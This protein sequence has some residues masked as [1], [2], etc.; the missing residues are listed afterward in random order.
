MQCDEMTNEKVRNAKGSCLRKKPAKDDIIYK[1]TRS[2]KI[3]GP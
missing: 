2:I 3:S 1:A